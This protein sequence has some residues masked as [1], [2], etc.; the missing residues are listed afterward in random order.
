MMNYGRAIRIVRAAKGLSQKALAA[1]TKL[2]PSF[3]SLLESGGRSPSAETLA[4]LAEGLKV[5][6]H[7]LALLASTKRELRGISE[8]HAAALGKYLLEILVGAEA[9]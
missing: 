9:G 8:E 1:R 3:I 4:A 5:P 6:V 7:L 2:D